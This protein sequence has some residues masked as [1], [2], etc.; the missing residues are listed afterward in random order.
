MA[1][2]AET[3]TPPTYPFLA[4]AIFKERREDPYPPRPNQAARRGEAP[5]RL[6]P[7]DVSKGFRTPTKFFEIPLTY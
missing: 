2:A 5:S 4:Y 6:P 7:P 3:W 1:L